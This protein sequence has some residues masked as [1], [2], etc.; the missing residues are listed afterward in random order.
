MLNENDKKS[1]EVKFVFGT[2]NKTIEEIEEE[3]ALLLQKRNQI[4]AERGRP[5]PSTT[6]EEAEAI[7][8]D[9]PRRSR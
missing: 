6:V 7:N 5:I 1:P 9:Y 3:K 8:D 4:L 2:G